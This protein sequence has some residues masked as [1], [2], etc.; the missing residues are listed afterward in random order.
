[1]ETCQSCCREDN[2]ID[3][4]ISRGTIGLCKV[5]HEKGIQRDCRVICVE[6]D[7]LIIEG[8][9]P[10]S[11]H[12]ILINGEDSRTRKLCDCCKKEPYVFLLYNE[13]ELHCCKNCYLP[14]LAKIKSTKCCIC[15]NSADSGTIIHGYSEFY[16]ATM[17]ICSVECQK[18]CR[19]K[20]AKPGE[21]KL[22]MSCLICAKV[23]PYT[24]GSCNGVHYC[25][26]EHQREDWE[27]H[28]KNCARVVPKK[29]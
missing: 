22:P 11:T 18:E 29:T 6:P 3:L 10:R 9:L 28:K 21:K 13:R 17:F 8:T 26:R 24:C 15:R 14:E 1:M 16:A 5:C 20:L 7:K 4:V 25:S 23:A 19:R 12:F 27:H 2:L